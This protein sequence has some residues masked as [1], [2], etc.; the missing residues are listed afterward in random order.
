MRLFTYFSDVVYII[1]YGQQTFLI[2]LSVMLAER[3]VVIKKNLQKP[4]IRFLPLERKEE[5]SLGL[6]L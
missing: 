5:G 4:I 1:N 3:M 6:L 2:G